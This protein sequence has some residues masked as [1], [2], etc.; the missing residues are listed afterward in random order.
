MGKKLHFV[1]LLLAFFTSSTSLLAQTNPQFYNYPFNHLDWYT[2][3]SENFLVHFQEGNS[4]SAQTVSRIAEEVYPEITDLYGKAPEEKTSIVLRD[5]QDYSNGAAYFFDNKIDIWVPSLDT[6]LRGTHDWF[7]NVIA[8]EFTHIVQIG[9]SMK[10]ERKIPAIYLQWISYEDVRRPDVLYGFP[11]GIATFPLSTVSVP[12]WLAEGTAQFQRS[13]MHYDFWDTHRDMLLRTRILDGNYLS[14]D[15]MG[16]F[17][18]KTSLERELVYNQGFAFSIYIAENYGEDA[19]AA[20][21]RAS[22][23]KG[24][25]DIGKIIKLATGVEGEQLFQQFIE[26]RKKAYQ[27]GISDIAVTQSKPVEQKGFYNFYPKFSADGQNIAYVSNRGRDNSRVSLYIKD[28]NQDGEVARVDL[29][30]SSHSHANAQSIHGY[31]YSCGFQANPVIDYIG[32][33][34]DFSPDGNSIVYNFSKKNKFGEE[35]NDLYLVNIEENGEPKKLTK[36][37]RIHAPSWSDDGSEI[38]T[39]LRLDGTTNVALYSMENDSVETLTSYEHGEQVYTP[40][41]HPSGDQIY[42]VFSDSAQR[43]I[44][45]FNRQTQTFNTLLAKDGVDFRDPAIG[46]DGKYLYYAA[47]PDGI[48]NIYRMSLTDESNKNTR[49]LTN[50]IGGAFMPNIEGNQ[51]VYSEYTSDGYKIM[52]AEIGELLAKP[53]N[54]SYQ[55]PENIKTKQGKLAASYDYLNYY[56]TDDV[57]SFK[58]NQFAVADTGVYEFSIDTKGGSDKR[59]AYAYQDQFTKFSFFPTIRFDNYS[60]FNGSNSSLIKNGEFGELGENLLRDMK[61]G[62]NFASREVTDRLSLFGGFLLG[63]GSLPAEGTGDFFTPNRLIDLDRDIFFI[64]EFQGLPFID[65]YWSPTVSLE[66]YNLR[67]NVRDGFSFEEFPCTSCLPQDTFTDIAYNVWE[68]NLFFRSK[69]NRFS[70]LELGLGISPQSVITESFRSKE[71]DQTIPSTSDVFFKGRRVSLSYILNGYKPGVNRDIAPL[72][73]KGHITYAYEP[74]RLLEEFE[75][76]NGTLSPVFDRTQNQSVE[77]RARYGFTFDKTNAQSWQLH[78]RVFSYFNN[79]EDIFYLD[80][81]GGF[82]NMRSYPF[83][84]IGGNTT[85]FTQL[86]FTTPIFKNIDKQVGRYT[87]DKMFLRLFAETGNGWNGD[88]DIGNNLK[89][90]IGSELRFAFNGYYLFPFKL[91]ISGA[92]GFNQFDVLL[93]NEFLTGSQSNRVTYGRD[94]QIHFGLTFDFEIL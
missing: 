34:F 22:S 88:L 33:G 83:F 4:R 39:V 49:K 3:E 48:F 54:G 15:D 9:A 61:I 53:S 51:L 36:S 81:A 40:T 32:T 68:A 41:W 94:L 27:Q 7:R 84:A 26:N 19:L 6:P 63:V 58:E 20:I 85:A 75:V 80:Y 2:V 44:K 29:G 23:R 93:P 70:L 56:K 8:H 37:H 67:R 17:S 66:L 60:K 89:T 43:Q 24:N 12:G 71:L 16:T 82:P 78:S 46:P 69:L 30:S 65:K 35:Y 47:N 92:Y 73:W 31:T 64:A 14:F 21:T 42:Y 76:E 11:K 25:H 57:Q 5:R 79:P 38:A 72:G 52:K 59:T 1:L 74:N 87:L 28:A 13:G 55:K 86:S 62:F 77:L 45:V 90:G 91:F 18:S 50:V 10:R